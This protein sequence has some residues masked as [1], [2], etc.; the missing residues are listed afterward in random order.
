MAIGGFRRRG[1]IGGRTTGTGRQQFAVAAMPVVNGT[2]QPGD[3]VAT[4]V[5]AASPNA[6]RI[7][8]LLAVMVIDALLA[9]IRNTEA[10]TV[11]HT[12]IRI[13]ALGIVNELAVAA[14]TTCGLGRA[15]I[16]DRYTRAVIPA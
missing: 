8:L 6:T 14:E 1:A 3:G 16:F 12:V 7:V 11:G 9:I 5:V 2:V 13:T 10:V 15:A 4:V